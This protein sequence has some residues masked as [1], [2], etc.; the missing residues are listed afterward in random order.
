MLE[1]CHEIRIL[2]CKLS[3]SRL[4]TEQSGIEFL[5]TFGKN[6]LEMTSLLIHQTCSHGLYCLVDP[7]LL[8]DHDWLLYARPLRDLFLVS[9]LL[10]SHGF[11]V[12]GVQ[13]LDEVGFKAHLFT[14]LIDKRGLVLHFFEFFSI[15]FIW[16][17]LAPSLN[18]RSLQVNRKAIAINSA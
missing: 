14:E 18:R 6:Q 5:Q 8:H 11:Q 3:E 1:R 4:I 9:F 2:A 13:P 15:L 7:P 12:L 17:K 16:K 10:L